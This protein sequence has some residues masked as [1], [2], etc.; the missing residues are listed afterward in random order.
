MKQYLDIGRKILAE[1]HNHDDRTGHGRISIF[2]EKMRFNLQEGFPLVTSKSV[3]L[4][5]V[6]EELLWFIRGSTDNGELRE[7][8]VSIWN[9][10]EVTDKTINTFIELMRVRFQ[11]TFEVEL[12][13]ET[14]A[15]QRE[16]LKQALGSIGNLYGA[17]WRRAPNGGIVNNPLAKAR[18]VYNAMLSD[19]Q[20]LVRDM[21]SQTGRSIETATE[22]VFQD[23]V[24]FVRQKGVDQ[25]AY[26]LHELKVRPY[27]S[28]LV[29]SAWIPEWVPYEGFAP[30]I[31]VL[32]GKGALAACHCLVQFF[33]K[34]PR[35]AGGKMRLSCLSYQRS[36]DWALGVPF[37]IASYAALTMMV[38]QVLGMEADEFIW[39]GGDCHVYAHH[40]E[41]FKQQL[42]REPR[43]L[44][45]LKLNPEVTDLLKFKWEDFML[46]GYSPH[47][48]LSYDIAV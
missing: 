2:A 30:D 17:S 23:A 8:N 12:S 14:E 16:Q 29:I 10:W 4:R 32:L 1:G 20:E 19:D 28:R 35:E 41:T 7:K 36:A 48:K 6:I 39:E 43:E 42:E 22:S 25:L 24:S 33:V 37:N 46:E 27:S 45:T 18:D 21:L 15:E 5:L 9:E 34:P 11:D 31:N 47:P 3:P 40:V 13:K 44:P 38:A 26:V